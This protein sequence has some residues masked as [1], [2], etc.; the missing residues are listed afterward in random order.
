MAAARK[1]TTVRLSARSA[2]A[3]RGGA[4]GGDSRAL[5]ETSHQ[6][7]S[8]CSECARSRL[9]C[10]GEMPY[11]VRRSVPCVPC[12]AAT[13]QHRAR[14]TRDRMHYIPALV[15]RAGLMLRKLRPVGLA[16]G[17]REFRCGKWGSRAPGVRLGTGLAQHAGTIGGQPT[18]AGVQTAQGCL[19]P[20]LCWPLRRSPFQVSLAGPCYRIM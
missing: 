17:A 7:C 5:G 10:V 8:Y 16:A 6:R 3:R 2:P 19:H 13:S 12:S 4:D 18:G 1:L 9:H 14:S 11:E 20:V 15:H